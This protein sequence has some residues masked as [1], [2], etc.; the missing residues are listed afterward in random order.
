MYCFVLNKKEYKNF[1]KGRLFIDYPSYVCIGEVKTLEE[2]KELANKLPCNTEVI[3]INDYVH[4]IH[5]ICEI[6]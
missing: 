6:Y 2:A 5:I 3:E 1:K 4:C